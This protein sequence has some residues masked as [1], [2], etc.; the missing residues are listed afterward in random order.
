MK[1]SQEPPRDF[2]PFE[3]EE[4]TT[5]NIKNACQKLFKE[6]SDCDVLASE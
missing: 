3:Y 2:V 6:H 4:V 5:D 1:Y